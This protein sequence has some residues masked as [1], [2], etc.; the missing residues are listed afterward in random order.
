MTLVQNPEDGIMWS[1]ALAMRGTTRAFGPAEWNA[2]LGHCQAVCDIPAV[3]FCDELIETYPDAK[4][5][6]TT[7]NVDEWHR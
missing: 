3:H 2:L 5:I 6:L 7:R 4:V 1:K